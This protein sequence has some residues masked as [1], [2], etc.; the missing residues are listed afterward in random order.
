[1]PFK[2]LTGK[3]FGKLTVICELD[4]RDIKTNRIIWKCKCDCGNIKEIRGSSLQY[5]ASKSCGCGSGRRKGTIGKS[6]YYGFKNSVL[7]R[8]QRRAKRKDLIW[9]LTN[10]E[11]L[12]LY[13]QNCHY[14]NSSPSNI[15]TAKT[16]HNEFIYNGI[17]RVDNTKGY[18]TTNCVSCCKHCNT[19]KNGMGKEE[20]LNWCSRVYNFSII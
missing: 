4:Q 3:K 15:I 9:S 14:C 2:D 6:D 11:A 7:R 12:N 18:T 5:G 17:D 8:Y 10:E 13:Q 16:C 1:M 19:A 20:F